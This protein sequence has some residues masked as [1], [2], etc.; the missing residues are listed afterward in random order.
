M[1]VKTLI[2]SQPAAA[3]AL[4]AP[5]RTPM[6][7]GMFSELCETTAEALNALGLG[8]N[9]R[10]AMV[11]PNGPE[12][13]AAFVACGSAVTAAPLNPAYREDEFHVYEPSVTELPKARSSVDW[14]RGW[15]EHL[16]FAQIES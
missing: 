5:G 14:Y 11:L 15:R 7:Y 3:V 8:R 16:G 12:M 13:A 1:I 10:L 2:D 9:D 4:A 6:T